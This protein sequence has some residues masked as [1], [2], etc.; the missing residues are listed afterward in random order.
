MSSVDSNILVYSILAKQS[1]EKH[2]A[3]IALLSKPD[4]ALSSQ[5]VN[6]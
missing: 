2:I 3:A 1:P 5:V 4:I 6:E